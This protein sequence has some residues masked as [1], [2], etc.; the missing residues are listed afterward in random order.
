MKI[1]LLYIYTVIVIVIIVIL[2][3]S[4]NNNNKHSAKAQSDLENKE[5]PNDEVHKGFNLPGKESPTKENVSASVSERLIELKTAVEKKPNDTLKLREYADFLT[6]AHRP[7]EAVIYYEKILDIDSQRKDVLFD[8][9]FIYYN[10]RN[11]DK[12]ENLTRSML[13]IYPTDTQAMY[14]L[15]AIKASSGNKVEAKEIWEKM[16]KLYPNSPSADLA[17]TSLSKL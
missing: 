3:F 8:L 17:K 4:V 9:V 12:A 6:A 11:Y 10:K 7:D 2:F 5:M 1:K 16:I 14:N 15:G 13:K